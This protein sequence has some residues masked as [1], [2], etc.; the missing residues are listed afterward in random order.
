MGTYQ[1]IKINVE[2]RVARISLARPPLNVFNI[3]MMRELAAAVQETANQDIVAI[4]FEA[5]K[6]TRAFSAGVAVEEHAP[7]TVYQ[8]LDSFHSVFR[9][10]AVSYTHLRAHE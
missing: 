2:D 10:L 9:A 1:N 3:A 6:E 5:D 8:M 7:E 4:V